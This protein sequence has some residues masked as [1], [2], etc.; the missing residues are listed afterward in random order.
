MVSNAESDVKVPATI[1]V[2]VSNPTGADPDSMAFEA[3]DIAFLVA[4]SPMTTSGYF[5]S[6][7]YLLSPSSFSF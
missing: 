2:T 4:N 6:P 7:L 5:L 3:Y 1:K